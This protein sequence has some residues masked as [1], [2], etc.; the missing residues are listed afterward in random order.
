MALIILMDETTKSL[1]N[2]VLAIGVF[3]VF[4]KAFDTVNH[5]ILSNKLNHYG[6]RGPALKWF[7]SFLEGRSQYVIYNGVK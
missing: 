1:E 2:I 4:S 6:I 5:D 3:F 7:E